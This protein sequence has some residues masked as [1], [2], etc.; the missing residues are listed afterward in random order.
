MNNVTIPGPAGPLQAIA[1]PSRNRRWAVLCHPHP[2]YG[3]SMD[4][5]VLEVLD[6]V[7]AAR[8]CGRLRFNFRGVGLSA[9]VFDN[10]VGETEDLLAACAWL[11]AEHEPTALS[12]AGYSFGAAIAWRAH[13]RLAG[14]ERLIL[15]APPTA[16]L[17][18]EDAAEPPTPVTVIAGEDDPYCALE[19]F[20]RASGDFD[21]RPIA[22]AD[23][24]FSG[25][26]EE[27]AKAL[28]EVVGA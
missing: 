11:V 3:G 13:A 12:L 9:G 6:G 4:D 27:L 25:K 2:L 18:L 23:H 28:A 7:L 16:M 10:G 5:A 8:G 22:G 1:A 24:F 26:W 17:R 21:V 19:A 14:V 20:E 15:V